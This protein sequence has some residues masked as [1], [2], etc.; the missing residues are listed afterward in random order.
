MTP[1]SQ[2]RQQADPYLMAISSSLIPPRQS[3]E[4]QEAL[5]DQPFLESNY[6]TSTTGHMQ[7]LDA[8]LFQYTQSN[9]KKGSTYNRNLDSND[10]ASS[11]LVFDLQS[12]TGIKMLSTQVMENIA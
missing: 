3:L 12:S 8:N 9:Q 6:P 10:L 2:V 4:Q 5:L 11:K 1:N 7:D